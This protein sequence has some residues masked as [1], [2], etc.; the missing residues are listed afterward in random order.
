MIGPILSALVCLA[1]V[2][3]GAGALVAPRFSASQYG[4]VI[5]DPRALAL[6]RAMG[7][8]DVVIGALIA[9]LAVTGAREA[10]VW[11]MFAAAPVALIDL[12]LVVADRRTATGTGHWFD[13]SCALHAAG[14]IG[15][16]VTGAMLRA[17]L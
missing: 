12:A 8:R 7:V 3:V 17:G 5:D 9:L 13:R 4:I 16:L 14:A 6:I 1:L 11:A 2:A 15:L 10:L